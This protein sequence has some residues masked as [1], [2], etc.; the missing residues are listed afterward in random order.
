MIDARTRMTPA[1]DHP[2]TVQRW[3]GHVTVQSGSIVLAESDDA[4]QLCE[5][6]YPVVFYVPARRR[7]PTPLA[8]E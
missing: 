8:T 3:H 7:E 4:L 1:P 5:A 6:A 2:I